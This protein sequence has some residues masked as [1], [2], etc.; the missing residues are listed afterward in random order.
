MT[1]ALLVGSALLALAISGW[2]LIF[3][4]PKPRARR[5]S[6]MPVLTFG[7]GATVTATAGDYTVT[8]NI[9]PKVLEFH[10][11]Y[12][13]LRTPAEYRAG[14][15]RP[16]LAPEPAVVTPLTAQIAVSVLDLPQVVALIAELLPDEGE[17]HYALEGGTPDIGA[18][19][20]YCETPWPCAVQKGRNLVERG[21]TILDPGHDRPAPEEV[22]LDWQADTTAAGGPDA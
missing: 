11:S 7:P 3:Y 12:G 10:Q 5:A 2:F 22:G 19:C 21:A 18:V 1:T 4:V 16:M 8:A 15:H 17:N 6:S 20:G 13:T 14:L 9:P